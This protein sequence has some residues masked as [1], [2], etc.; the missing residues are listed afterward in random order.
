MS[1]VCH[2]WDLTQ[3]G[4]GHM[5][6]CGEGSGQTFL[7]ALAPS[8][9]AAQE[10]PEGSTWSSF[11]GEWDSPRVFSWGFLG[12]PSRS[13]GPHL[14]GEQALSFEGCCSQVCMN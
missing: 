13:W 8:R 14:E 5:R 7:S 6:A 9:Y 2:S 10:G 3:Y 12:F 4:R 1:G 11:L